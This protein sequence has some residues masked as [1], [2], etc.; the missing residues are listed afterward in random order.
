MKRKYS[1]I[2]AVALVFAL[3]LTLCACS[4]KSKVISSK[5]LPEFKP[6][7][8]D[9]PVVELA[10]PAVDMT[11]EPIGAR[12]ET[13]T[14]AV[15]KDGVATYTITDGKNTIVYTV[16]TN[17]EAVQKG[18]IEVK[19]SFNGAEP[20][21]AV[22]DAGL[23]FITKAEKILSA[24][25]FAKAAT[26]QMAYSFDTATQ[27]LTLSYLDEYEG[28][29]LPKTFTFSPKG[30][31]LIVKADSSSAR[32]LGGYHGF[33]TGRATGI[34]DASLYVSTYAEDLSVVDVNSAYFLSAYV[35][36]VHS[37]GTQYMNYPGTEKNGAY[38]GSQTVY[39]L[40]TAGQKSPISDRFYIT[41]S[42]AMLDCVYL[43]N[44]AKSE[45][46]DQLNDQIILDSWIWGQG[47]LARS[48][49]FATLAEDYSMNDVTL[50]EHRWQYGTLDIANPVHYPANDG[51]WGSV[52]DFETYIAAVKAAGWDLVLHEDYWFNQPFEGNYYY[53]NI[54]EYFPE[55]S[56]VEDALAK[57]ANGDPRIGWASTDASYVEALGGQPYISYSNRSDMMAKYANLESQKIEADY[58][59]QGS[60][61][62][63]NGGVSPEW[64][65]Q[66]TMDAN[67]AYGR[68]LAQVYADN[69]VLFQTVRNN[70]QGPVMS[71][72][73]QGNRS[74]GSVYAGWLDS[75]SREISSG[76]QARIMPDYEL[77]YI[78]GLMVN[79]GMGPPGRFATAGGETVSDMLFDKYNATSIAYG[80]SGFIGDIHYGEGVDVN[81]MINV[82]Y[83]FRAL[84]PQYLD[85]SVD[86]T[87]ILYYDDAGNGLTLEEAFRSGYNFRAARLYIA[88]SNGLEIYLNFAPENWTVELNGHQYVLDINGWAAENPN[89]E[90]VEYSC[91]IGENRVDYVKCKDYTYINTRGKIVNIDGQSAYGVSITLANGEE[92][93]RSPLMNKTSFQQLSTGIQ[94]EYGLTYYMSPDGTELVPFANY[95]ADGGNTGNG[96]W[97]NDDGTFMDITFV[98]GDPNQNPNFIVG[99]T[100]DKG[101]LVMQYEAQI[102][103]Y[104]TLETWTSAY[105]DDFVITVAKDS[106]DNVIDE[107]SCK[108]QRVATNTYELEVKKGDLVYLTYSPVNGAVGSHFG[109]MNN[110]SYGFSKKAE[111]TEDENQE[112]DSKSVSYQK[113]STGV[114]GEKGLTYYMS[115]DGKTLV[116]FTNFV[117]DGG[118]TSNGAWI[119][120]DGTVMDITFV[121]GDPNQNPDFMVGK[122][123]DKGS[124]VMEYKAQKDC[125][126]HLWTWTAGYASDFTVTVATGS[127]DNIVGSYNVSSGGVSTGEY[128]FNLKEGD[129]IYLIYTP[130]T[131]AEGVHFGVMNTITFK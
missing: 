25:K 114:Q 77:K 87:S 96:A 44:G 86:V 34:E 104:L 115:P 61:L 20:I 116:P 17:S 112:T 88:Y 28:V 94:G 123:H 42:D 78:R 74:V 98:I 27:T 37:N 40:N 102:D 122:V 68:T 7:Q 73:A 1:V 23:S 103:G 43:S 91:L 111:E 81:V 95:V 62:D 16:D 118:N 55:F 79:Q 45:F 131:P 46:R 85:T 30:Y 22:T 56:K 75:S 15:F 32:G 93:D 8:E 101:S 39:D 10:A 51:Q 120:D 99:K 9:I 83:M 6:A 117:E 29:T 108:D 11:L 121:K 90:F 84:Q 52:E 92:V 38:H 41:V 49:R 100:S 13:Q 59:P 60:F 54:Q 65:S 125:S 53:H 129:V 69:A 21:T 72:G 19:A 89:E 119:N 106:R 80:H 31:S 50:V 110:V 33:E 63:V 107:F 58:D 64:M 113:L 66:L 5:P 3:V 4:P 36:R 71:E 18:L 105:A 47:Y 126:I 97:L 12:K 127:L 124:L 128:N 130:K 57:D 26:T 76:S 2:S 67:S 48:K 70:Y 82:Y 109:T 14:K 24:A 35:D